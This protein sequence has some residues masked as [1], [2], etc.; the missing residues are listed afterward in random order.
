MRINKRLLLIVSFLTLTSTVF[1]QYKDAKATYKDQKY[2]L[3]TLELNTKYREYGTSYINDTMVV[4]SGP[5][6]K[7]VASSKKSS[8]IE[9]TQGLVTK[10]G[11]LVNVDKFSMDLNS[12]FQE[13]DFAFTKD[14]K[15]VY[16]TSGEKKLGKGLRNYQ[17]I[18]LYGADVVDGVIKD[19]KLLQFNDRRHSI[20]Q[21]TLADDDQTL[22]FVSDRP[23]GKG[24]MDLYK[25]AILGYNHYG[26]VVNLGDRINSSEDEVYPFVDI[27]GTLYFSSNRQGSKGGLDIYGVSLTNSLDSVYQ[28][29]SPV[30]SLKDD[31]SFV[32]SQANHGFFS[33]NRDGGRGDDDIY[34]LKLN[35][36]QN[37]TGLVKNKTTKE[38]LS[39]VQIGVYKSGILVDS[40]QT[41]PKGMFTS[42]LKVEADE[43]FKLVALKKNYLGDS[44]LITTPRI[45][46]FSNKV[47]LSLTEII[48]KKKVKE[49]L[50]VLNI[51]P[52]Y[53]SFDES[54]ID[55]ESELVLNKL[56]EILN[57][58]PK[59]VIAVNSYTDVRGGEIWNQM[60]SDK[61]ANAVVDYLVSKGI[62]L[63]RLKAKGYGMHNLV[64]QCVEG[65]ICSEKEHQL[66][67]RTEFRIISKQE[68]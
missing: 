6:Y 11:D 50:K 55:N 42:S 57:K 41:N 39:N 35:S 56:I 48:K 24:K 45:R 28:L 43:K 46:Y 2:R 47:N 63:E 3:R 7:S 15:Y 51:E 58:H 33:S 20:G 37:I 14:G 13:A 17:K 18:Q 10:H 21:P 22:Y 9:L 16:F 62:A 66:N 12:G 68:E 29:P 60:L 36:L 65:V 44:I 34:A 54:K 27:D 30:N 64:N 1:S 31:F 32:L 26:D 38:P 23:G 52:I 25:V 61:R 5:D 8:R 40:L 49:V 4:Y 53:Y 67:R 59:I 19:I